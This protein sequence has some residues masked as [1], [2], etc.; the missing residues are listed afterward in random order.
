L[1][2]VSAVEN[3]LNPVSWNVWHLF[4]IISKYG[5]IISVCNSKEGQ[6]KV[7]DSQVRYKSA[8]IWLVARGRDMVLVD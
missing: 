1:K 7:T 5:I 8:N 6:L 4:I 3:L 2:V